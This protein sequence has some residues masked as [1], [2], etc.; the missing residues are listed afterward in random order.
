MGPRRIEILTAAA[1]DAR[2]ARLWYQARSAQAAE[3]FL[4]DWRDALR[5]IEDAPERWPLHLH[6][7]RKFRLRR[8]PYLVVY[9]AQPEW[10]RVIACQHAKRRPS[11]WRSRV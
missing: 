2:Y 9:I 5:A 6:G 10:I 11:Y 8:F 4:K 7:T 3:R 1:W